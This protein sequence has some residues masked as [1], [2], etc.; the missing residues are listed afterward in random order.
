[1]VGVL[2]RIEG[3]EGETRIGSLIGW[4]FGVEPRGRVSRW[5]TARR[6]RPSSMR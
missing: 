2:K 5:C 1:M 4:T 3:A 6:S